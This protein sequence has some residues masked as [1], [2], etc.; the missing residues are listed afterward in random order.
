LAELRQ[1]TADK[2][3]FVVTSEAAG[4]AASSYTFVDPDYFDA[5]IYGPTV[6]RAGLTG[7]RFH[8]LRRFF[9]STLMAQ[10]ESA[11]HVCDQMGHSS[12]Q[13]TFDTYGHPDP[14]G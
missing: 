7:I 1:T 2:E 10:G 8:D 6:A 14:A 3:G 11:K 13:V 12:I 4:L 9:A 5:S